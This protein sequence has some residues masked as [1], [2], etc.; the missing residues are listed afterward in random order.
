MRRV[1]NGRKA[2]YHFSF[3]N[4]RAIQELSIFEFLLILKTG[5]PKSPT[6]AKRVS[7]RI[8]K[9]ENLVFGGAM[10]R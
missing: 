3:I 7:L 2:I 9:S 1:R 8:N 10:E 4:V 6:E 5:G